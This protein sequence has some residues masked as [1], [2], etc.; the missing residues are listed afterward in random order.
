MCE[1]LLNNGATIEMKTKDG[2]TP[3]HCAARSGHDQLIELLLERNAPISAKTKVIIAIFPQ[4]F[5]KFSLLVILQNGLAPLHMATQGDHVES[6][7][8]LLNNHAPVDDVTVDYLTALH[9]AAHCG[10]V[11][12]A[13]LLLEKGADANSRAL[14]GFTPLHI[15]CKKNRIKVVELLLKH[16]ANISA[17]TES[18]LTP[19]HVASFMGSMNIVIFLLQHN[20]SP[21]APTVRGETPLHLAA[22]SNQVILFSYFRLRFL[23]ETSIETVA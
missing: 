11:K 7:K 20:A 2:L 9:V 23:R 14:N 19:L 10:H 15:A 4:H 13:K 21:D 1:L 12:V 6:A 18:G 17:T 22:R 16:G 8:I 3:L 5:L